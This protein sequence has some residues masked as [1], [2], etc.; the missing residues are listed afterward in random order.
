MG[1][2]NGTV[3]LILIRFHR[4]KM[5]GGIVLFV[6]QPQIFDEVCYLSSWY[7]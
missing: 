2:L 6:K 1:R 5:G 4:S 7:P 3:K